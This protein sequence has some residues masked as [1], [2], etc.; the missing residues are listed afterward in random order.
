[1]RPV[2]LRIVKLSSCFSVRV[3]LHRLAAQHEC[4][5]RAVMRLQTQFVIGCPIRNL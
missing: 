1:M 2:P 5:P 4:R 3:S